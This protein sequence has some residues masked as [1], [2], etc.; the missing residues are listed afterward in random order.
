MTHASS[1]GASTL[2]IA[3]GDHVCAMYWGVPDRDEVM[4]PFVQAGL[5]AGDACICVVHASDPEAVLERLG[6]TI[7]VDTYVAAEQLTVTSAHDTY[8]AGGYFSASEMLD[9]YEDYVRSATVDGGLARIAGEGAWVVDG[10]PGSEELMDYESQL[11]RFVT[12]Y[13]QMILCLY[14]L[15][16]CGGGMVVDLMRTHPK[17]LL[18]GML[19]ENPHYLSPDEFLASRH[20]LS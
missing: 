19:I 12:R 18:G 13:P 2:D 11:N 15:E 14:D 6:D 7:D 17:I 1:A 8:L 9:Y 5:E 10:P 20:P 16:I 3:V 4:L